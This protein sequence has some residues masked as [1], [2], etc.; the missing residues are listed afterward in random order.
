MQNNFNITMTEDLRTYNKIL[1]GYNDIYRDTASLIG[2]SN[3]VF[4]ILY[5]ICEL[6]NGCRQSDICR[7]TFIPKQTV[8]SSI[9]KL[10]KEGFLRLEKGGGRSMNIFLT[11]EGEEKIQ[12]LMSPVINMEK[13]AFRQMGEQ[14]TAELLRLNQKYANLLREAYTNEFKK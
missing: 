5:A 3:S 9:A 1:K 2:V 14:D 10:E 4:D 13:E 11:V 7:A 8:N 6:G 12:K